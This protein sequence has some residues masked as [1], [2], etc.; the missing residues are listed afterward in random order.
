[1]LTGTMLFAGCVTRSTYNGV[2][3]QRDQLSEQNRNLRRQ[4]AS[5]A[6]V[7]AGLS[8]V[9]SLRERELAQLKREQAELARIWRGSLIRLAHSGY[10][11]GGLEAT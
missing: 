10:R 4:T 8:A 3:A 1:M 6:G 9:I 2:V 7:A 11:A 5:V